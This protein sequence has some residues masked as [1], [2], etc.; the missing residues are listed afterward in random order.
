METSLEQGRYPKFISRS[1]FKIQHGN[2]ERM[3]SYIRI[4]LLTLLL[5]TFP[6]S[7]EEAHD[8][9]RYET[10]LNG[11][12]TFQGN[13][14]HI[15][16]GKEASGTLKMSRPWKMRLDYNP[17]Q[18]LIVVTNEKWL[19]TYDKDLEES[20]YLSLS[21]TPAEFILRPH[22]QFSGDV[23]VTN[24]VRRRDDT[25]EITLV[26][27]EEHD[28]GHIT[29]IF[30][31]NPLSLKEWTIVD[32]QGSKTTVSLEN[33]KTDVTFPDKLFKFPKPNVVQQIF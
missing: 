12:K 4:T 20:N 13:F 30:K 32:A 22:I 6:L 15:S 26:K 33:V 24:I 3:L 7:A 11:L 17:P 14:S 18:A 16:N 29:L 27:R 5:S 23:E 31:E 8:Y 21:S 9:S 25:T 19:L 2:G 10:Y 1:F 28:A